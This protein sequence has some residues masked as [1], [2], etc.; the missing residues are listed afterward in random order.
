RPS[1]HEQ[2][3]EECEQ[4]NAE[5]EDRIPEQNPR[6]DTR[7][8]DADQRAQ[9]THRELA[10]DVFRQRQRRDEQIAEI[11]RVKLLDECERHAELAAEE[12]IPQ[13][14]GA[15]EKSRRV[16]EEVVSGREI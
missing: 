16:L 2:I 8:T 3:D 7:A 9:H 12:H 15:D 10:G 11:A 5:R 4:R 1:E 14:Y 6:K 13:Q